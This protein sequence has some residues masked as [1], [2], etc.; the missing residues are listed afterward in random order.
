MIFVLVAVGSGLYIAREQIIAIYLANAYLNGA[1]LAVFVIGVLSTFGQV[2][3]LMR[4]VEWIEGFAGHRVGH[5]LTQAPGLLAPLATLLRSRGAMMQISSTSSRSIQDSVAQRI[6]EDREITRYIGNTLIFL[7]L[8]GTFYGLATTVPALV[9]TIRSLNPGDGESGADVFGRLQAGLESQLGG[10]GT[11]FSSSLLGLAGSLVVGLLELFAS[12]GQNRFY[13]ELEEWLSTITRLGFATGEDSGGS[14]ETGMMSA[15][16]EHMA[17]QLETM[18]AMVNQADV[19]QAEMDARLDALTDAIASMGQGAADS[20]TLARVAAGQE[21]LIEKLE[22]GGVDG[23]DAESRMRLRSIDV[24]LLRVLEEMSAG[25]Q[26]TLADLRAD[27]AALTR[28]L[29]GRGRPGSGG[30]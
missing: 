22:E 16:A 1:I 23:L 2:F 21:R 4:S 3:Q 14:E 8:L 25:R 18:Q 26:E 6:D 24:Q 12:H 5:N 17:G 30:S 13:R 10:M 19:R 7:G 28:A 20:D 9:E 11:A 29:K 27:L 15:F